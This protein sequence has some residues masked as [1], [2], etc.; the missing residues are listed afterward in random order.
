MKINI[1]QFKVAP[2]GI[3]I[4]FAFIGLFIVPEAYIF[5]LLFILYFT[6]CI[7]ENVYLIQ[8]DTKKCEHEFIPIVYGLL[9][10]IV[11]QDGKIIIPEDYYEG[12]CVVRED[13]FICKKCGKTVKDLSQNHEK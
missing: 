1:F 3:F 11:D 9:K 7:D 4:A 13:K 12:G 2:L 5:W 10:K 6:L 8:K